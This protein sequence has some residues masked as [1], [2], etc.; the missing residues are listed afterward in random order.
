MNIIALTENVWRHLW[1]PFACVVAEMHTGLEHL[2]N[3]WCVHKFFLFDP[4][5]NLKF[6]NIKSLS[7]LKGNFLDMRDFLLINKISWL[8]A[9]YLCVNCII[10]GGMCQADRIARLKDCKIERLRLIL[11]PIFHYA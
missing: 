1:V 9:S 4:I 5:S 11:N 10:N 7:R 6:A 2:L 8:N 3:T